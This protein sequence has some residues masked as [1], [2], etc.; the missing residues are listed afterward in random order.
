M[1]TGFTNGSAKVKL[2]WIALIIICI[3]I[4]FSSCTKKPAAGSDRQSGFGVDIMRLQPEEK[5]MSKEQKAARE[6]QFYELFRQIY[7]SESK[8]ADKVIG[9]IAGKEIRAR[10][11][12][13]RAL[14]MR[15]GGSKSPY[16]DAWE[17]LKQ[18]AAE[19]QLIKDENL[20]KEF[21]KRL[22]QYSEELSE[23]VENDEQLKT[24]YKEQRT[25]FGMSKEAY[26]AFMHE[27]NVRICRHFFVEEYLQGKE[28]GPLDLE[29]IEAEILDEVY[30]GLI[31]QG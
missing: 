30:E 11:F 5:E 6:E 4:L 15:E 22:R 23:A 13:I 8:D 12:E 9:H 7:A 29:E 31:D 19:A 3:S 20:E 10:D 1:V 24:Y 17:A 18:E 26:R 21:S 25:A 14:K 2:C 28:L 27:A 16:G